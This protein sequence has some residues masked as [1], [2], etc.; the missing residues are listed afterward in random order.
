MIWLLIVKFYKVT[1]ANA[2]KRRHV[3]VNSHE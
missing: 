1:R 2:E 3:I